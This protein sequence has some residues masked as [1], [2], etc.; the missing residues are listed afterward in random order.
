MK[1]WLLGG[2]VMVNNPKF[3]I[4]NSKWERN[5]ILALLNSTNSRLISELPEDVVVSVISEY[6]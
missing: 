2:I 5:R 4:G 6:L 3:K 1:H